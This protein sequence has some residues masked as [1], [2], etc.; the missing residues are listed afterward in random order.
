M[1]HTMR[2]EYLCLNE[3]F[4]RSVN[5]LYMLPCLRHLFVR[6]N[7]LSEFPDIEGLLNIE[8]LVELDISS[9]P[10]SRKYGYRLILLQKMPGLT[11]LDGQVESINP[12]AQWRRE[13]EAGDDI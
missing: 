13:R 10:L 6:Y 1:D 8:T 3:N 9:N 11:L 4:L 7:R 5:N 2:L 12:A